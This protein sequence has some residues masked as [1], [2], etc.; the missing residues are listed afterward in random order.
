MGV[1]W[2]NWWRKQATVSV[3]QKRGSE[4]ALGTRVGVLEFYL[5]RIRGPDVT[6]STNKRYSYC[7]LSTYVQPFLPGGSRRELSYI[8]NAVCGFFSILSRRVPSWDHSDSQQRREFLTLG[9]CIRLA[10]LGN[11]ENSCLKDAKPF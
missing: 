8:E 10:P 2:A 3:T 6:H 11:P 1:F 4:E 7:S 5:W 9:G